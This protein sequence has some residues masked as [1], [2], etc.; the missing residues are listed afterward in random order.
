[1][2][3][4]DASTPVMGASTSLLTMARVASRLPVRLM[5]RA[6]SPTVEKVDS[7]GLRGPQVLPALLREVMERQKG[8]E[9][10]TDP[11]HRLREALNISTNLWGSSWGRLGTQA[12]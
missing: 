3:A 7:K 12:P 11:F 1:M 8:V 9:L 2:V 10:A 6:L 4:V 5:T